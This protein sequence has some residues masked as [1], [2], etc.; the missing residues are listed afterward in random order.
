MSWLTW[1]QALGKDADALAPGFQARPEYLVVC[2]LLP[3]SV[4]LLVGFSLR[5]LEHVLGVE[6]GRG[7]H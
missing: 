7:G 6:L 4:G 3:V 5:L 2:V 1:L